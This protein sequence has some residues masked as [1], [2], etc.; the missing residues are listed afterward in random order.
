MDEMLQDLLGVD[1]NR[2]FNFF[3]SG[4]REVTGK[5]PCD[6]MIYVATV[7]A[8][9]AQTSRYDDSSIRAMVNLSEVFERFVLFGVDEVEIL[10]IGGSQ[11]LLL[12]GF[13]RDQM[14]HR[15][16]L[17]CYDLMGQS[18]YE[19]AS[20]YSKEPKR[21]ELFDRMSESFPN[22]AIRCC[23]LNRYFRENRLLIK[24]N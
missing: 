12:A 16:N 23:W 18:F 1:S 4:L 13:F 17:N 21:Q 8:H 10:E 7:L 11:L 19:R 22:W 3:L 9:Y 2:V 5:K 24:V 6:E 15:Y 20:F 14:E